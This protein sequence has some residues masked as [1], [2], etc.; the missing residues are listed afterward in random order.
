MICTQAEYSR[1]QLCRRQTL[2]CRHHLS[3]FGNYDLAQL[4]YRLSHT[5]YIVNTCHLVVPFYCNRI[6][7]TSETRRRSQDGCPPYD[8]LIIA[9]SDSQSTSIHNSVFCSLLVKALFRDS[10]TRVVLWINLFII[11]VYHW[12]PCTIYGLRTRRLI[13]REPP[14]NRAASVIT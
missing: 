8:I 12:E 5:F 9:S 11:Y 1:V 13:G 3:L 7:E 10:V 4:V 2:L 14:K 6:R